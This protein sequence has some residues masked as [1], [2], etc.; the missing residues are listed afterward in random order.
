MPG[1]L[2]VVHDHESRHHHHD[3]RLEMGGVL[4]SWA[5][6]KRIDPRN[7]HA[8]KLA[9]QVDDHDLEYGKWEGEIK[10]GYGKGTVKIWDTGTFRVEDHNPGKKLVFSLDGKR[11]KGTFVLVH[12]RPR[13]KEWLFFK[14]KG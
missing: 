2:F 9:V 6:P 10:E 14:K 5:I 1:K 4:K 3:L 8:R 7:L 11:L 13:G 12:F